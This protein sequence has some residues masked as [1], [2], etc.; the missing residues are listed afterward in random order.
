MIWRERPWLRALFIVTL[1][2]WVAVVA[3]AFTDVVHS[4]KWWLFLL[5][6]AGIDFAHD[7]LVRHYL[8]KQR[9]SLQANP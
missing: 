8:A 4:S 6:T 9:L 7:Q 5:L 1:G 2:L 3:L